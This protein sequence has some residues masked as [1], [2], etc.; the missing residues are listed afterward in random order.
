MKQRVD[1]LVSSFVDYKGQE[2]KFVVAAVSEVLPKTYG[3]VYPEDTGATEE[4][5]STSVGYEVV[6]YNEWDS[7]YLEGLVKSLRLGV[8]ICN[9]IDKFNERAG[10]EKA[11]HRAKNCKH[12]AL[13][14]TEKGYIN[15]RVVKAMLEQEAHYIKTNP[16][17]YI[18]G[19]DEAKAKYEF[20]LASK[21]KYDNL[22]ETE[23]SLV[24]AIKNIDLKKLEEYKNLAKYA[25]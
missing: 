25:E 15:T 2:H 16:G 8:A 5:K 24:L 13:Y 4:E 18:K 12:N 10:K 23:K 9:P 3:E 14:S 11:V 1:T 21:I 6:R 17:K 19:Y 22:S 20:E 7:D